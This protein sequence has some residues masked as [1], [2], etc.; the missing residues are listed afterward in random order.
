MHGANPLSS[1]TSH[2]ISD[3]TT[4]IEIANPHATHIYP[5]ATVQSAKFLL[6]H[7]QIELAKGWGAKFVCS[8]RYGN[9][10]GYVPMYP[11]T[12]TTSES[13]NGTG[14]SLPLMSFPVYM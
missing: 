13:E 2:G 6:V 12:A 3:P 4:L 7:I 9:L 10:E 1:T 5:T 8:H 14:N 11:G